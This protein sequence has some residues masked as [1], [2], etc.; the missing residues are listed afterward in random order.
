M[1]P[2]ERV[3]AICVNWNGQEVLADALKSLSWS[4]GVD[5]EIMVVDNAS[6]DN[7]L[8]LV[9]PGVE[10]VLR[11]KNDGYGAAVNTVIGPHLAETDSNKVTRPDY[12]LIINNDVVFEADTVRCLVEF[13]RRKGPGIFGPRVVS[14]ERP[15]HLEMAWGEL[16]WSHVLARFR[17]KGERTGSHWDRDEPVT[18]L[19]GSVLLIHR[20]VFE[21][22]GLFDE[23]FFM[24]HE[25]VD[26]LYRSRQAG[27]KAY[28][29][30][31]CQVRHRGGHSTRKEPWKRIYWIRRNTVL[32]FRKHKGSVSQWFYFFA[33][34]KMS[35]LFNLLTL[36]WRRVGVI[37][38]G[39]RDG[40]SWPL[41]REIDL[42]RYQN[43]TNGTR[44]VGS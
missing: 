37:L 8:D 24:Y 1:P 7:S 2:H 19:M 26:F 22:I 16:T 14:H 20:T 13:A 29:C 41:N 39:V 44:G 25:E 42:R 23:D 15:D 28:F 32:F 21:R 11:S 10:V 31:G 17:G 43:S 9:P 33:S 38:R 4:Q 36:R 12:Y 5:L 3:L 34:L 27:F 30:N 40:F 35:I 6:T 18:L